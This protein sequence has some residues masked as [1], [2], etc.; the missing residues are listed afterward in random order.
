ME[1]N[2]VVWSPDL[3]RDIE[4]IEKVQRRFTKRLRGLKKLSYGQRLKLVN[5]PSL[6]VRRLHTDLLWC[7]KIVVDLMCDYFFKLCPCTVTRG[8]MYK[9]YKPSSTSST[10]SRYF[11]CRVIMS[12]TTYC[13]RFCDSAF[14][15]LIRFNIWCSTPT[16]VKIQQHFQWD[17]A[18]LRFSKW[19][20]SAMLDF[21]NLQ[22][23]SCGLCRHVILLHHTKFRWNRTIGRWI[24][25]KKANFKMAVAAILNSK[26]NHFWLR[27]CN[28]V[29][30][31]M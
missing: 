2:G 15:N 13:L 19:W 7:Y 8:H 17:V 18:I 1:Y 23:L 6:E 25:T 11:A 3:K 22:F 20:P 4:A 14:E 9:L 16:F 12:G 21:E 24:M 31:L 5:L 10:M 29:Q 27:D 30:Y 26:K 28:W